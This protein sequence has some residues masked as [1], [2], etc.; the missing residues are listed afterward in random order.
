MVSLANIHLKI[1]KL[2]VVE[3]VIRQETLA[4]E[5]MK[6][7]EDI[8]AYL[9]EITDGMRDRYK[10]DLGALCKSLGID[11]YLTEFDSEQISGAI[12]RTKDG[13][14]FEIYTNR[15]HAPNRRRF[16]I[17]HELGHYISFKK[18]SYSYDPFMTCGHFR[19]AVALRRDHDGGPY[20]NAES[21]ANLIAAELLM[22]EHLVNKLA[23]QGV[24]IETM[25]DLFGVSQAAVAIRLRFLEYRVIA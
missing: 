10:L 19:D 20:D 18:G 4:G 21:E 17:A 12:Y 11:V 5:V 23:D 6:L 3:F 13:S 25:A 16:T 15:N 8:K 14:G 9:G 1:I 22:P 7:S 24:D 2:G